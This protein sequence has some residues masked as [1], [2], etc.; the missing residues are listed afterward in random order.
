[1]FIF[2]GSVYVKSQEN[3]FV[4]HFHGNDINAIISFI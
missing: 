4:F 1:M 2:F 3:I